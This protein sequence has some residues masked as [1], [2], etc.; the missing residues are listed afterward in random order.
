MNSIAKHVCVA[1][2]IIFVCS[3]V[4][5]HSRVKHPTKHSA[6]HAVTK[7]A[8]TSESFLIADSDGNI[9][10]EH[11]SNLVRPIAS[12]TKL[13]LA[14]LASEQDLHAPLNI[15]VKRTVQSGISRSQLQLSRKELLTL[16]LVKS[17]N[18]AALILCQN[19][20]N[21]INAM[22]AK[23]NA[24]G[25]TQTYFE[26]PTGLSQ[27]NVS[28]ASD[29]LKLMLVASTNHTL[30]HLS[31]MSSAEIPS[32]KNTIKIRNTN[33]LTSTQDITL[34]KTGF[35]NPAGGCISMIIGSHKG[36]R[37]VILLGSRN[38]RT[39]ITESL[40]LYRDSVL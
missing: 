7:A 37:V 2:C 26:E 23:A 29:L 6:K 35:T 39:R 40:K 11:K 4:M 18:F 3:H 12:I 30:T 22:N 5:A 19:I 25:M 28:T 13:L 14:L 1:L 8:F 34:S 21:C 15:P 36:Q 9:L 17:D 33:P 32:G 31:S 20:P 24:L 10:K 38:T 27:K 16:A